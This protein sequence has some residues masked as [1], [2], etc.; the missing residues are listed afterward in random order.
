MLRLG[1]QIALP[2]HRA[3]LS[4]ALARDGKQTAP[5]LKR[6]VGLGTSSDQHCRDVNVSLLARH[7]ERRRAVHSEVICVRV[8]LKEQAR[9][10]RSPHICSCPES[11]RTV[12]FLQRGAGLRFRCLFMPGVQHEVRVGGGSRVRLRLACG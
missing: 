8:R 2:M 3:R 12:R 5:V 1:F 11:R 9:R 7:V 6:E 10:G 4:S